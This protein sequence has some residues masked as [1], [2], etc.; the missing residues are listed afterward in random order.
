MAHRTHPEDNKEQIK[1]YE[2]E[3]KEERKEEHKEDEDN[4]LLIHLPAEDTDIKEVNLINQDLGDLIMYQLQ[5]EKI[6]KHI[7]KWNEV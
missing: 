3:H 4:K 1:E 2:E 7:K 5:K 6:R